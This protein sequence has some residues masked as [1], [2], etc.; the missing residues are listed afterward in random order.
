MEDSSLVSEKLIGDE[1]RLKQILINLTKS[2][3]KFS[4]NS[5]LKLVANFDHSLK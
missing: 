5:S 2:A 4:M 3:L 1:I